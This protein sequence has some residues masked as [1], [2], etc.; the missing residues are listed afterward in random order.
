LRG[1][2]QRGRRSGSGD[3]RVVV[4]LADQ[5]QGSGESTPEGH[6]K[7]QPD[8][9]EHRRAAGPDTH[10]ETGRATRAAT[11]ADG[12]RSA[13]G[14]TP[15][16]G[17][18]DLTDRPIRLVRSASAC[19]GAAPRDVDCHRPSFVG[20]GPSRR[21]RHGCLMVESRQ[22]MP[23]PPSFEGPAPDGTFSD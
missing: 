22:S 9:H 8:G 20:L 19:L 12:Q 18:T 6:A 21:L 3:L 5:G 2:C 11:N 15:E 1:A 13:A 23:P 16:E 4:G 17:L 10:H 14:G 7:D